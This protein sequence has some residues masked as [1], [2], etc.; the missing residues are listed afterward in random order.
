MGVPLHS[1]NFTPAHPTRA[2]LQ[3]WCSFGYKLIHEDCVFSLQQLDEEMWVDDKVELLGAHLS[4][5]G[6]VMHLVD[7]IATVFL[8]GNEDKKTADVPIKELHKNFTLH[9]FINVTSGMHE[10]KSGWVLKYSCD[11]HN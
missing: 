3:L 2:E 5:I 1:L 7:G 8:M 6:K 10:G 9:E 4:Q 11:V